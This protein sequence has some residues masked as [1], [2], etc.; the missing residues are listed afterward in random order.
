LKADREVPEREAGL[1]A[2]FMAINTCTALFGNMAARESGRKKGGGKRR[3][4]VASTEMKKDTRTQRRGTPLIKQ[5]LQS[6]LEEKERKQ[7]RRINIGEK[8]QEE[9]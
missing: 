6:P 2:R 1:S 8:L 7:R 3:G 5:G 9:Q 4:I